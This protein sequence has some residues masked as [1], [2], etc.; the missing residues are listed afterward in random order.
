MNKSIKMKMLQICIVNA[1]AFSVVVQAASAGVSDVNVYNN[2]DAETSVRQEFISDIDVE[3]LKEMDKILQGDDQ[4]VELPHEKTRFIIKYL[5]PAGD[6]VDIENKMFINESMDVIYIDSE[7]DSEEYIEELEEQNDNIEYIQPDYKLLLFGNEEGNDSEQITKD[8][9]ENIQTDNNDAEMGGESEHIEEGNVEIGS[10]EVETI[11]DKAEVDSEKGGNEENETDIVINKT[12]IVAVI[13][14]GV[15]VS[16]EAIAERIWTNL[17][18]GVG[19]LIDDDG[20]GYTD[21]INGWDFVENVPLRYD[22]GAIVDFN[23]GTHVSGVIAGCKGIQGI[24]SD[25]QIMPLKTFKDGSAYTSDIIRAIHYADAMGANVINCSFGSDDENIALKETIAS[26]DVLFVC[27]VG[28]KAKDIDD[29]PVYPAAYDLDNVLSVAA[30][31]NNGELAYFSNFGD[32]VDIAAPGLSIYSSLADNGYGRLS[33]TSIAAAYVSGMAANIISLENSDVP[34]EIKELLLNS[35]EQEIATNSNEYRIKLLESVESQALSEME[36]DNALIWQSGGLTDIEQIEAGGYHSVIRVGTKVFTFGNN[37]HNQCSGMYYFGEG[38]FSAPGNTLFVLT[39]NPY[40]T[41]ETPDVRKISTKGDHTLLLMEDGTVR[42]MG[43]NAYGQL[44]IGYVGGENI[45]DAYEPTEQVV[46]LSNIVDIAAGHQFSLALDKD[47]RVYAWGNNKDGQLGIG[48]EYTFFYAPQF[49]GTINNVESISAGYYHALAI[50][51]EG[52]VYGWGR[53]YNGA[54][55]D[56]PNEKYYS[57]VNLN[58]PSVDKVVAGLDNSFFIKSD[59]TVYAYGYNAYGQ[60][61]DGTLSGRRNLE[62]VNIDNV[63]DI[64][65]G[66][67]T[68]FLKDDGSAYGCGSNAYG[69]LGVGIVSNSVKDVTAIQGVYDAVSV[70]GNH[71]LFLKDG[72][73]YSA[74][75][76]TFK[77]CGFEDTQRTYT[78]PTVIPSYTKDYFTVDEIRVDYKNSKITLSGKGQ[79][80][81]NLRVYIGDDYMNPNSK[82]E[83]RWTW[84]I[85]RFDGEY[86]AAFAWEGLK[87]GRNYGWVEGN[88]GLY[89]VYFSFNYNPSDNEI[90]NT[91]NVSVIKDTPYTFAVNVQDVSDIDQKVFTVNYDKSI[92]ALEDICAQTWINNT[93]IGQVAD[94]GIDIL[95]V[96]DSEVQFKTNKMLSPISGTIN[97]IKFNALQDGDTNITIRMK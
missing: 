73:V 51:E 40:A 75:R 38:D 86:S 33:G 6:R 43:A 65:T 70:G 80:I 57:P 49:I 39:N 84:Q 72:E 82:Y 53:A 85:D 29:S 8:A 37:A 31:D 41:A 81:D 69:Q 20:N 64:S 52:T 16:H 45:T 78:V 7:F 2:L 4:N 10:S 11:N 76:N 68:I 62:A 77:Q 1:I 18:E 87:E 91:L 9:T 35:V 14:S 92:L 89:K 34:T 83:S 55:G 28:N 59:K 66:F 79:E 44:G 21:D 3:S 60:L 23:H 19:N 46:G 26:T 17:S 42:A 94:A 56:L 12:P 71:T 30:S 96:S 24:C 93:S 32:E 48:N 63:S 61:G 88:E 36:N 58:I 50:T 90:V 97:L 54:L 95:S 74:G 47:G 5:D 67:A 13:D 25:V 22:S 15:D 27:A